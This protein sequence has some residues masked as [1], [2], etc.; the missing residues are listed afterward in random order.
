MRSRRSYGGRRL[1]LGRCGDAEQTAAGIEWARCIAQPGCSGKRDRQWRWAAFVAESGRPR[2]SLWRPPAS[3][4]APGLRASGTHPAALHE[5][6][7]IGQSLNRR[8]AGIGSAHRA[9]VGTASGSPGIDGDTR[10]RRASPGSAR[11]IGARRVSKAVACRL[12]D[13]VTRRSSWSVRLTL[14]AHCG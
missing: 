8:F 2:S 7:Q 13:D 9:A 14:G 6:G 4:L 10:N 1:R 5:C 11:P 3:R 12:L